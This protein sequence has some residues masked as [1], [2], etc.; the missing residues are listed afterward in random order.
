MKKVAIY[1]SAYKKR[2]LAYAKEVLAERAKLMK[3]N[4]IKS[5]RNIYLE[6]QYKFSIPM[7]WS[8]YKEDVMESDKRVHQN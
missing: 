7:T 2:M 5:G 8:F 4:N 6:Q 1:K 3:T